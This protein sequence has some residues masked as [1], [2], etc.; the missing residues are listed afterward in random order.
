MPTDVA[1]RA[2]EPFFTTKPAG[3]GH[4]S[5]AFAALRLRSAVGRIC[6]ARRARQERGQR[7]ACS[8]RGTFRN[9]GVAED[10]GARGGARRRSSSGTVLVVDDEAAVR[11][12]AAQTVADLGCRVLEA[13]D[14]PAA[15]R[16]LQSEVRIDMLVTDVGLPGLNGRQ[17]ADAARVLR[18]GL[19]GAADHRLRRPGARRLAPR[20]R[21]GGPDQTVSSRR[22]SR[23][24]SA[25]DPE[26][27]RLSR[28]PSTARLPI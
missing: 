17:L 15:L 28:F 23:P 19:A 9:A 7:C 14:G 27:I 18:P 5:R 11:L 4:R 13:E 12:I 25:R 20:G 8:S 24:G 26:R 2:F 22:A 10:G 21:Y 16:M 6:P 3:R 1:N